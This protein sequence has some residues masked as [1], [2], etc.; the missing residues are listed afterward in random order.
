[1]R[2]R[3]TRRGCAPRR[4][5]VCASRVLHRAA[6]LLIPFVS[7]AVLPPIPSLACP[8]LPRRSPRL[9]SL[10]SPQQPRHVSAQTNT[11]GEEGRGTDERAGEAHREPNR[12]L[13]AVDCAAVDRAAV[14]CSRC[15][16]DTFADVADESLRE[17]CL[18][19][20]DQIKSG[21]PASVINMVR[22]HTTGSGRSGAERATAELATHE[23]AL[24][25]RRPGTDVLQCVAATVADRSSLP[26]VSAGR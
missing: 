18:G 21:K 25:E 4:S 11:Q 12:S 5:L 13:T 15:S 8:P 22:G 16:A 24:L 26:S 20:V 1:M 23:R 3:M 19:F 7:V 17:Q 6:V 9:S 14:G 2:R 10:H